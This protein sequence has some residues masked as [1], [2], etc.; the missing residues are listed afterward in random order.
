VNTYNYPVID[1]FAGPGGLGEGFSSLTQANKPNRAKFKIALSIEKDEHAYNTLHLRHFYRAFAS[2]KVPETYYQYLKAELSKE[3]LFKIHPKEAA[4]AQHSAWHCELGT[5]S[6]AE[7][8]QR[9]AKLIHR[10]KKWVLVGGPP[11][12]AYSLV[13]RSRM[14]NDPNFKED[15]RHFLYKE[16]LQIL[17]DHKPPV[18]VME[19]VPGLLSSKIDGE[20]VINHI[21]RDL[22][23]P[24]FAIRGKDEGK[25]YQLYS[26]S[27]PNL[28]GID[29]DPK[30]FIVKAEEYGIPQARHRVFILG[31]RIDVP[32]RPRTLEKT[33][34]HNL[35]D[36]IGDLPKLRSGISKTEDSDAAW[37]RLFQSI[38]EQKWFQ[39]AQDN[40]FPEIAD[41]TQKMLSIMLQDINPKS[42]S[43]YATPS[44]LKEWFYDDRLPILLSHE[45]RSHMPSDLHRYYFATLYAH[46]KRISPKIPDF[47]NGLLPEHKNVHD[48]SKTKKFS[49][50]FRVQLPHT[51]STTITSH[52]SKDGHYFIHYDPT[53]SRSLTVREAARIQTF[54]D[55]YKFEGPRT[56]Q[57]HQIGNAVPPLL[58]HKIGEII[59]SLLD[60]WDC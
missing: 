40:G 56:E 34:P 55:N 58:A 52:I 12:Q 31:V 54:P 36:V 18:F 60:E 32:I 33:Q 1:I 48:G 23:R 25:E 26:L 6:R 19:N 10:S 46:A 29:P 38:P 11:C 27:E 5:D 4:S 30:S 47:P 20:L 41:L 9:I 39:E 24:S 37:I 35:A 44:H 14:G 2:N 15:H 43:H 7:V 21:V 3:E 53:Q 50:R 49:D 8:R 42:N 28:D 45:T 22:T 59:G 51:P 16:Y 13:G 17:A 57:Y